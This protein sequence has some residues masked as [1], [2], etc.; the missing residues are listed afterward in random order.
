MEPV[1]S[2]RREEFVK[3][4]DFYKKLVDN[5]PFRDE[6]IAETK[7]VPWRTNMQH[8]N[9]GRCV[10]WYN[11]PGPTR[12]IISA[13]AANNM[14]GVLDLAPLPGMKCNTENTGECPYA[15]AD[16]ANHAPFLASGGEFS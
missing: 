14:T 13:Q 8:F 3:I 6:N 7:G 9:E 10:L 5:S 2:G 15:S 1:S 16:G 11:Y 12:F 4:L